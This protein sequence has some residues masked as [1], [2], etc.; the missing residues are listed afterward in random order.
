M[1]AM[2]T[3]REIFFLMTRTIRQKMA[4]VFDLRAPPAA[5]STARYMVIHG[6]EESTDERQRPAARHHHHRARLA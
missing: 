2:R 3:E 4:A 1:S 6:I 5:K